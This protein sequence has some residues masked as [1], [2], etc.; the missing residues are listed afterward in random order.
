LTTDKIRAYV[1]G[2]VGWVVFNNPARRNA[3]SLDMWRAIPTIFDAFESNETVRAIVLRGAGDRAFVSGLDISQFDD[4]FSSSSAATDLEALSAEANRRI[5]TSPRP[6]IA[7]IDGFCIG[8]G[9][10]LAASCDLRIAA[11]RAVFAITA[12]RLGLGYPVLALKGLLEII[13]PNGVK[14]L[15][16]TARQFT[17]AEA[18]R[19]GLADR[20]VAADAL[21]QDVRDTC[22]L[23]AANAPL[24]IKAVK[25]TLDRLL[26]APSAETLAACEDLMNACLDST[27]YAEGRRAFA[28]KRKPVFTGR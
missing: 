3:I 16:F 9:V 28:E 11:E 15:F 4:Q 7:M 2:A 21:E 19:M 13:G 5:Q 24:T 14:E 18:Q 20:I 22:A 12:A 26:E 1:D 8:A 25:Q 27:D 6:T 17:A 23:I 10:Q